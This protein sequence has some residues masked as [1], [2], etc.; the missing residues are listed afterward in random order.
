LYQLKHEYGAE[1]QIYKLTAASTDY[2]TGVKTATK[3]V[4]TVRHAVVMPA[5]TMRKIFQ[6]ISYLSA[7]KPFASQGGQGWDGTSRAFVFEGRDLPG[8]EWEVEDWIVYNDRRYDVSQIE[9]LDFNSGWM[10]IGKEVK[11]AVPERIIEVNV[12]ETMIIED[13]ETDTKV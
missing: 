5:T 6:G 13:E 1:V 8:Y 10:I 11:G 9:E 7:S 2:E 3:S 12:V 4:I